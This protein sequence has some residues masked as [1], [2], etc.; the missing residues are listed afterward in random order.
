MVQKITISRNRLDPYMLIALAAPIAY[1]IYYLLQGQFLL[2][3]N[4][5]TID[6]NI[7]YFIAVNDAVSTD[8][9]PSWTR[10]TFTGFP[11]IGSPTLLWYPPNWLAFI[12]DK[13][14]VPHVMT[15]LAWLHFV[16]VAFAGYIFFRAIAKSSFWASVS[17]IAYTFSL[18]VVYGLCVVTSSYLAGYVFTPLALYVIHTH[19]KRTRHLTSLYIA[20]I[21]F[22]L[23]TGAFIQIALY[24]LGIIFLYVF[25]VAFLG[26][27][28]GSG[29]K[30]TIPYFLAGITVGIFLSAPM[31][32][33]MFAIGSDTSRDFAA[34]DVNTIYEHLVKGSPGLLWRLF[35][36]NAFGHDIYLPNHEMG[37][38]NYVESMNSFC[39]VI[40][41]FLA[42]YAITVRRT[43]VVIFFS[44][45]FIGIILITITPLAYIHIFLFGL[46]PVLNRVS[47]FLPLVV[48][49]LAAIGGRHISAINYL[50][51]KR[52][53]FNPIWF[54][55]LIAAIYV[56]PNKGRFNIEIT[57]GIL[58][59]IIFVI[60]YRF[61]KYRKSLWQAIVLGLVSIEVVWSGHLMTTAQVY[62]LM[63]RPIDFYTYGSPNDPFPVKKDELELYRILLYGDLGNK[64]DKTGVKLNN[65]IFYNYMSPWGYNNAY[66]LRLA[67]LL[68][69]LTDKQIG[70][71]G[72]D[73]YFKANPPYDKIADLTSAGFIVDY[74]DRKWQV[75]EDRRQRSLPRIGLFYNYE[76]YNNW[77]QA[78]LRLNSSDFPLKQTVILTSNFNL[79]VGPADSNSSVKFLKNGNSKV[80]IE[81]KSKTPAILLFNDVYTK[82]WKAF[83]DGKEIEIMEGNLAFRAVYV[84]Q[85]DHNVDF[86]YTPPLLKLSIIILFAGIIGCIIFYKKHNMAWYIDKCPNQ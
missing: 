5:D 77:D 51:L 74:K 86:Q 54:L 26:T 36:P 56:I 82:G 84:P 7:P 43:P 53:L 63:V 10:Y 3:G 32:L 46:K 48:A 23:V 14:Y 83:I 55:L 28:S 49:S 60:T 50:S 73:V 62:P 61:F 59:V 8:I 35:S 2:K 39:G 33:P 13:A 40:V 6:V 78:S 4:S 41:L 42:G 12:V 70:G 68:T 22:A 27:E 76:I 80:T 79:P 72:R 64:I 18:P 38:V 34:L 9:I 24:S 67:S 37:G 75:L 69:K 25:A 20:L 19:R 57:R 16:G 31:L 81:T 11:L 44:V 58:F 15:A 17:A 52:V 45:L 65:G 29:D 71:L 85:G 47:Y 66:P 30:K 1:C 21:I